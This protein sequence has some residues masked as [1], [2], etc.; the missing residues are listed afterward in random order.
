MERRKL[1]PSPGMILT[2]GQVYSDLVFL[3]CNSNP[4]D[5]WEVPVEEYEEF[6]KE[7]EDEIY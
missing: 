1:T 5:W 2:N 3:G 7:Q 4:E 6:L